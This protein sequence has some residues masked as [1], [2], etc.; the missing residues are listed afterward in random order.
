MRA[1]GFAHGRLTPFLQPRRVVLH[2]GVEHRTFARVEDP[3]E[4]RAIAPNESELVFSFLTIAARMAEA[5]EPIQKALVD[6]GL[7][8]YWR[9]WGRPGDLGIVAVER[10]SRMPV[11]CAWVRRYTATDHAYGFVSE[12][13]PEL[14]TGT[15]DGFRDRGIGTRTL[16]EL[17]RVCSREA[18]GIS[19]SVRETNPAVRLYQRLGFRLVPGSEKLNRVG[20][21][22]FTMLLRFA[23][24]EDERELPASR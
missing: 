1:Y 4:L 9:G 18:P 8:A 15:I 10:A 14:S 19:L 5:K 7:A 16:A 13:V 11:S 24:H 6:P 23:A 12:D 3:I 22:S 17:I 20:T 2:A 21:R